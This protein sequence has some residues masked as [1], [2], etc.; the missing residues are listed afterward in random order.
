MEQE[1]DGLSADPVG[2]LPERPDAAGH[3]ENC[4]R[5][6]HAGLGEA[7]A[8]DPRE[9][10]GH[11]DHDPVVAEVLDRTEDADSKG[12]PECLRILYQ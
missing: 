11:P 5:G 7:E 9:I 4:H 6:P 3:A 8:V 2:E 1:E 12:R 10:T